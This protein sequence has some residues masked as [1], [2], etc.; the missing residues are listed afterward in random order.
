MFI[1]LKFDNLVINYSNIVPLK[2]IFKLILIIEKYL[3]KITF[4]KRSIK[5][6]TLRK[7]IFFLIITISFL[8]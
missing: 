1:F 6:I 7:Y 8:F 5:R 4:F 3:T 2:I